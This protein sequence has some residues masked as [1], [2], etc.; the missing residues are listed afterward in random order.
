M[1]CTRSRFD[2]AIKANFLPSIKRKKK[3]LVSFKFQFDITICHDD[4]VVVDGF[5]DVM[6][7]TATSRCVW[8]RVCLCVCDD[9]HS[10]FQH[11]FRAKFQIGK[12]NWFHIGFYYIIIHR[13][14]CKFIWDEDCRER[15][16][17]KTSYA[18]PNV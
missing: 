4:Y 3:R 11:Q 5:D 8:I 1:S 18:Q 9:T 6:T 14:R 7:W 16:S 15:E 12:V 10:I 2:D 13:W 17:K